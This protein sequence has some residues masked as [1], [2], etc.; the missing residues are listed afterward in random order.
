[1]LRDKYQGV[2][3]LVKLTRQPLE[4]VGGYIGEVGGIGAVLAQD[5]N[6]NLVVSRLIYGG[7]AAQI[8]PSDFFGE[9]R[10]KRYDKV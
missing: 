4:R 9:D 1:M 6:G 7:A 2:D 10:L 5:A 3:R 8:K